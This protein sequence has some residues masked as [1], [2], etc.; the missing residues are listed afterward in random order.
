MESLYDQL[1]QITNNN[2]IEEKCC[3]N[4]S[5]I[6]IE[7]EIYKCK[8]CNNVISNISQNPEWR[9]YGG[10][11]SKSSDPTRCG[12]PTNI[13]LPKSSIGS[14]ISRYGG[15]SK[16]MYQVKKYHQWNEMPY[17]ERSLYKVFCQL[18]EISNKNNIPL[19]ITEEAK[20]LYTIISSTKISRGDNRSGII[21]A[22]LYFSCKLNNV[23]RSSKEIASL[24]NIKNTVMT[25]GCKKFQEIL[26]MNKLYKDRLINIKSIQPIDL[27]DRCC[28]YFKLENDIIIEIK[29]ICNEI[30]KSNLISENTPPSIAAACIYYIINK[31]NINI[32]KKEIAEICNISDVT[33][34]KCFKKINEII[35]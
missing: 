11:D 18:Y 14:T 25:K 30:T 2:K 34:N 9:Y 32:C 21:A 31:N 28:N 26:H 13:L 6:I 20:G 33:I 35:A 15:G 17:K 16:S 23:P 1:D 12:M 29:D 10:G 8:V 19:K 24:F 4:R 3:D 5:N 22:C 27:I 7:S